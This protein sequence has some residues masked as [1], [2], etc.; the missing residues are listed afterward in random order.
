VSVTVLADWQY[1]MYCAWLLEREKQGGKKRGGFR[2]NLLRVREE[3]AVITSQ[4]ARELANAF[5]RGHK[6]R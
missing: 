2:L 5:V 6:A 1:E 4:D 3:A